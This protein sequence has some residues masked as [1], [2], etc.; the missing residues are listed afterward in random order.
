MCYENIL[1]IIIMC[2]EIKTIWTDSCML[3]SNY[4]LFVTRFVFV[5][6][7]LTRIIVYGIVGYLKLCIF[8]RQDNNH[9]I[10]VTICVNWPIY[11]YFSFFLYLP[12]R[13]FY[14]IF[15]CPKFSRNCSSSKNVRMVWGPRRTKAGTKPLKNPIGPDRAVSWTQ[16]Q[17][18]ANSP[19][20]AFIMRVF[21]T[22][23][24]CVSAVAIAP[25]RSDDRKCV[26]TLSSKYLVSNNELLICF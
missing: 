14:T 22:S 26:C 17:T 3:I 4:N 15:L 9:Y 13:F 10:F 5:L 11:P 16:L 24:G 18:L 7:S 21:S 1:F 23:N 25:A 19:G 8:N 12:T 6:L 20:C 2:K